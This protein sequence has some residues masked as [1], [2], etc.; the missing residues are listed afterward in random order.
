M[1]SPELVLW[2]TNLALDI[3]SQ[4]TTGTTLLIFHLC[5]HN[6]LRVVRK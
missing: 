5:T 6:I 3:F 2:L 1:R 4:N